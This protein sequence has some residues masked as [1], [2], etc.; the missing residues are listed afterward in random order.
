MKKYG[1]GLMLLFSI[2]LFCAIGYADATFT[3]PA[4]NVASGAT[5]VVPPTDTLHQILNTVLTLILSGLTA[6][7]AW[8]TP[9]IQTWIKQKASEANTKES[10]AW[11]GT[12]LSLAGIAVRY[13]ETKFGADTGTGM[14]KRQEAFDWFKARLLAIDPKMKIDDA[15]LY[16]FI[17]AAYHS[18][19][20]ALSPLGTGAASS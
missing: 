3:D 11:Y 4:V 13:A 17:D 5:V 20:V 7:V 12:A 1:L 18:V 8:A 10:N 6:M 9:K 16:G 2:A 19:F 15:A 14:K